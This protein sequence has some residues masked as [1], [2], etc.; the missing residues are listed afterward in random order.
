MPR[1]PAARRAKKSAAA[2][3]KSWSAQDVKLLRKMSGKEPRANIARALRR[4][5]AAI[6][7][8]A[9]KLRLS[10]R[11]GRV[12]RKTAAAPTAARKTTRRRKAK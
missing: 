8:K 2:P 4:S 6:T 11:V 7:F 1:K 5:P 3:S 10:L 9:F 12:S